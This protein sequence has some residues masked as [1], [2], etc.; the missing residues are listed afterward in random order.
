[1]LVLDVT[2]QARLEDQ[3]RQAQKMEAIGR[4]AGGV[5]H[6]FNNL[7]L[8][9]SGYA[10]LVHDSLAP[11]D[12]RREETAEIIAAGVRAAAL[13]SQLLAFGRKAV[14]HLRILDVNEV[15]GGSLGMIQRMIG[16][17]IVLATDLD[18]ALRPVR[19]DAGQLL[20]VLMNLA[21]N[22]RDAMPEGGSLVIRTA[23]VA[24]EA[25]LAAAAAAAGL[26]A[27]GSTDAGSAEPGSAEGQVLLSIRDT[28]TGM[29]AET[30]SHL[31]EP[32]FTTKPVGRGTGLGLATAYG[33]VRQ[34][35]GTIRAES[36]PGHGATFSI[37]LPCATG[38]VSRPEAVVDRQVAVGGHATILLVEDED[39]VRSLVSSVLGRNGYR[40]LEAANADQAEA[41]AGAF[42][43][44]I[45]LL[46]TDV[47]MP[48]RNGPQLAASLAGARPGMRV[49][50]MS[51]YAENTIVH[52]GMVDEGVAFIE[53]PFQG[54]TLLAR[55]AG[56]LDG[57]A[58]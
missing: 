30:R 24:G 28:G 46:L 50:F 9:I 1:V 23:N 25:G 55:V 31:F 44:G 15:V 49:L 34:L 5:A 6:D 36:E 58:N 53:K 14:Q 8:V 47:V 52:H 45:D 12:P 11:N 32:F 21:V 54:S 29:D 4:L 18:P 38:S 26:A 41:V 17:D 33:I 42:D 40:V 51:G 20:Q 27:P 19:A 39:K 43:G 37:L 10:N 57:A 48:G 3:F 56:L 16:E 35:G 22:A 7:L 2:E 13:T